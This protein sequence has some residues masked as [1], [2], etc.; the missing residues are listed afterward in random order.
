MRTGEAHVHI[1]HSVAVH[2]TAG[3]GVWIPADGWHHRAVVTE[4]GTVAFPLWPGPVAR[5]VAEPTRFD[6]PDDWQ[7]WLI[8]QFNLQITP[9]RG[10]GIPSDAIGDLLRRSPSR[11]PTVAGPET[12]TPAVPL[13]PPAMPR[14]RGARAVAE[15]LSRDPAVD[16]TVEQ[17][18][19]KV[20]SSPRTLR[21]DFLSGTGVTFE[22][23]RLDCRLSAAVEFLGS[24]YDVDQVAAR[25]GFASRNGFTRAFKQRFASTPHDFRRRLTVHQAAA[26][27]RRATAE[28][29]SDDLVKLVREQ[30]VSEAPALL[31]EAHT[32]AHAN[33]A[34][35]LSWVYRGSGYLDVA[36]RRYERRRGD[37]I[38]IPAGVEHVTGLRQGS[39]SLPVGDARPGDLRLTV[40]LRVRFSP[41]WDDFLMF[42]GI[43]SRSI[44][45]PDDHDPAQIVGLFHEQLAAQRVLSAPM[46]TDPTARAAATDFL[47]TIGTGDRSADLDLPAETHRAFREET[48]MTFARW[49]YAA[50]MR[51]ARDLLAGGATPGA[52]ARRV[53]YAHLPTFSAA[54]ARFHGVSPSEY[55][56]QEAGSAG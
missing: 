24:G 17:W 3:T 52:V 8:Q 44:L 50:R 42:H 31:P 41:A 1:D 14:T 49:R 9:L 54:F 28:R 10:A 48:G 23:W 16:L 6:V 22:Q 21:R 46:P 15:A 36:G 35:V 26:P 29:R 5:P 34:H 32:A 43:S 38:W 13:D 20:L 11:P 39:I 12:A 53:G 27:S 37:A 40:P 51:I 7:D 18:A 56:G 19:A 47:R 30:Q 25:V 2:L 55:R 33:D 4:P 45:Q